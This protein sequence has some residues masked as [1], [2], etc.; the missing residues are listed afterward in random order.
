MPY[1]RHGI[2]MMNAQLAISRLKHSLGSPLRLARALYLTLIRDLDGGT[3]ERLR[4]RYY[5]KRLRFIGKGVRIDT[6]VFLYGEEY[7]SLGDRTHIDK[8]CIIVGSSPD[9]DLSSR[10]VK[11]RELEAP[12]FRP[13]EVRIGCDCHISQ[14]CMIYGYGGVSIGDNCVM[15]AGAKLYSLTSMAYDPYDPSRV[16]SIVPY[17]GVSPTLIGKVEL[18]NNTWVGIDAVISP[19]LAIGENSF[20]RSKSVVLGSFGENSY[21]GGDPAARIRDRFQK[22]KADDRARD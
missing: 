3:G 2:R 9:L 1:A 15:S 16:V 22:R 21:I 7:I 4:Y 19:G 10:I 6:G 20:V 13:G 5:R 12:G 8:N 17:E 18:G 14:N 11:R